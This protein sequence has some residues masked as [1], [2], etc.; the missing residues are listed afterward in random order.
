M[1]VNT[2]QSR[3]FQDGA[4]FEV[5]VIGSATIK[6][7]GYMTFAAAVQAVRTHQ[8]ARKTATVVALEREFE[9]R[10]MKVPFYTAVG[11]SLDFHH[12][13]DGFFEFN[14]VV[15]TVDVTINPTKEVAKA[16]LVVHPDD[17]E[18]LPALAARVAAE[19]VRKIERGAR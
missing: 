18:N 17:L 14:G 12:G 2:L 3:L 7:T 8:P 19:F 1:R 10:G 11:S 15:V 9:R 13:V 16:D 6:F 5:E 4:D